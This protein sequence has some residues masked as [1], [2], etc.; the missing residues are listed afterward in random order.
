MIRVNLLVVAPGGAARRVWVPAEQRAAAVGLVLLA[1]TALGVGGWWWEL[2]RERRALDGQIAASE[3]ELTRLKNVAV[4]VDRAAA[5]KAEL[6]ERLGLIDRLHRTQRDPV[7]LL[8]AVSS[9]VPDGLWLLELRQQKDVVQIEGRAMSLTALTDFVEHLQTSGHFE[10]PV[11]IVTTNMES[12]QDVSV[13]RFAIRG[14]AKV[15]G[16]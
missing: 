14:K 13:V 1:I 2:Q 6:T 3:T 5:R 7:E 16:Q 9:A 10:R 15:V 11:D 8:E 4:L 12:V